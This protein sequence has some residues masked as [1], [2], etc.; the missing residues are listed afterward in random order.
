MI[1]SDVERIGEGT[2]SESLPELHHFHAIMVMAK[3]FFVGDARVTALRIKLNS[4]WSRVQ[5]NG[6]QPATP[7]H[8]F[9][10]L[11]YFRSDSGS[12]EL[13]Q[14]IYPAQLFPG[15]NIDPAEADYSIVFFGDEDSC[16]PK[17]STPLV[18]A[19]NE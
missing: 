11:Q 15:G 3:L 8:D 16:Q 14:K 10:F 18:I 19:K 5:T 1:L 12:L 9:K 2:E 17:P 4:T 7:G 6:L 13:W